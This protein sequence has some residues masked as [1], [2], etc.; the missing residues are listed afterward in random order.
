MLNIKNLKELTVEQLREKAPQVFTKSSASGTS[1]HYTF[2]PTSRLVEDMKK[3]GWVVTDAKAVK[4]KSKSKNFKKHLVTF[5][6]PN[7]TIKGEDGNPAMFPQILV[8]NSHDRTSPFELRV[9]IFVMVCEN[10]LIVMSEDLGSIRIRHM[11]YTFKELQKSVTEFVE[12]LPNVVIKI[13]KL[14]KSL[15]TE[16][17]MQEFAKKALKVRLGEEKM[18]KSFGDSITELLKVDRKEDEGNSVWAVLNR[19]QEKL[20]HGGFKFLNGKGKNRKAR[21]IKNFQQDLKLNEGLWE[22]AEKYL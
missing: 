1:K 15:M 6:N 22:L 21:K 2:V 16:F 13:N 9:G 20:T 4:S 11:G 7:I 17:Q 8:I 14:R 10:G 3:L 12:K 5:F 19:V 18:P